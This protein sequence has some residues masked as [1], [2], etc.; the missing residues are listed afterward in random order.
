MGDI[1][2]DIIGCGDAFGS[3]GQLQ[4]CFY[5]HTSHSRLLLD[6]GATAYYG[7][8]QQRINID[9]IDTIMI[10]HFHGDHYGG[11]PFLLLEEAI[12]R[13][14]KPLTIISPPTGKERITKL[15]DQLYPG[16]NVLGKLNLLFK[17]YI[18]DGVMEA[19]HLEV[20]AF[21][22]MH[23]P[24]TLPH[25]VRIEIGGKIISFS[26]DT[27]W[28]PV[29]IELARDADLFICEC[30]DYH[31]EAKGHM[32]YKTL[33]AYADQLTHKRILLTHFG[34]EMFRNREQID[35]PYAHDGLRVTLN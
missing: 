11:V 24:D 20:T 31:S 35:Y 30:N 25:G 3:G 16:S 2:V 34:T 5:I 14:E 8:K 27:A 23:T 33:L 9:D 32:N 22:V 4:T 18:T 1:T 28:T 19:D 7:I 12:R 6:C 17:T 15:L 10:S 29:L 13:R 21:P 26:G